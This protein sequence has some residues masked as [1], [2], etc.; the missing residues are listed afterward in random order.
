[1]T[2][3]PKNDWERYLSPEDYAKLAGQRV[4][5]PSVAPAGKRWTRY[6]DHY[7]SGQDQWMLEDY[8]GPVGRRGWSGLEND[9]FESYRPPAR[10]SRPW[11]KRALWLP[12]RKY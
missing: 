12:W 8:Q 5:P 4:G 6:L 1:M 9:E 11:W 7:G 3:P 10:R 2:G